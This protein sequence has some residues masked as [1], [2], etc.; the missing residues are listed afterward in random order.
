MNKRNYPNIIKIM[1]YS[2]NCEKTSK[3]R[4]NKQN[5]S[6]IDLLKEKIS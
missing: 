3:S 1:Y 2:T 6:L 4:T 5:P